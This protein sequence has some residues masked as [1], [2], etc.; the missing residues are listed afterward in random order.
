MEF[1]N[2][3]GD[4]DDDGEKRLVAGKNLGPNPPFYLSKIC[5][6]SCTKGRRSEEAPLLSGFSFTSSL[7]PTLRLAR[8]DEPMGVE[9][10]RRERESDV[11]C[12]C[13]YGS[14]KASRPPDRPTRAYISLFSRGTAMLYLPFSLYWVI[15]HRKWRE[16]KPQPSEPISRSLLGSPSLSDVRSREATLYFDWRRTNPYF[17]IKRSRCEEN[18]PRKRTV[19]AERESAEWAPYIA[20]HSVS[21]SLCTFIDQS[22]LWSVAAAG[23][24]LLFRRW[25]EADRPI[26]NGPFMCRPIF[27][28]D[29]T[30]LQRNASTLQQSAGP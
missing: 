8:I 9:S 11:R 24:V 15:Q 21:L 5:F 16:T 25:A 23:G 26:G 7:S 20:V 6:S 14:R 17:L 3:T 10:H 1:F 2:F 30:S 29:G 4:D 19:A 28:A 13:G 18:C 27:S 22:L 12:T